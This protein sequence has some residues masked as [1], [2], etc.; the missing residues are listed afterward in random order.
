VSKRSIV[1]VFVIVVAAVFFYSG[2]RIVSPINYAYSPPICGPLT[3]QYGNPAGDA[4]PC[5]SYEPP[6]MTR[7]GRWEWA[8]FWVATD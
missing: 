4:G 3:D 7:D 2:L 6:P 1:A 5:P 8:P